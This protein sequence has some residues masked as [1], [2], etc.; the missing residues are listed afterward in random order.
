MPWQINYLLSTFYKN[1]VVRNVQPDFYKVLCIR[2][3]STR[4]KTSGVIH[5]DAV[6]ATV[7]GEKGAAIY[8]FYFAGRESL[9]EARCRNIIQG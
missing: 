4:L 7:A 3:L 6:E 2:R 9:T 1:L 5:S 8:D